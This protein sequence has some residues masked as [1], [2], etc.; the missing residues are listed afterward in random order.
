MQRTPLMYDSEIILNVQEVFFIVPAS[1]F[2]RHYGTKRERVPCLSD[3]KNFISIC[4]YGT[5]QP[6]CGNR[7]ASGD[8]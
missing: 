2:L 6:I 3:K 7:I 8:N 1:P 4:E 5:D